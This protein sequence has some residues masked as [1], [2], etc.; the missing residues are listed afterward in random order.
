MIE[1]GYEYGTTTGRERRPGWL[2]LVLLK[3]ARDDNKLTSLA[4]TKLDVL[5]GLS[6]IKVCVAYKKADRV[7]EYQSGDADYLAGCQPVYNSLPGWSED[8][9]NIRGFQKLP[10]NAQKFVEF[11]ESEVK[12]PVKFISV[13]P[14]RGQVIYV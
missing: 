10:K 13:G 9:S 6:E 7:V 11:I 5:S 1:K 4:L 14:E 12:M 2:D 8:I 3:A